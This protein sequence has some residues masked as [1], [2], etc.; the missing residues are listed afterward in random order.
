MTQCEETVDIGPVFTE[1]VVFNSHDQ[2]VHSQIAEAKVIFY[3]P[4][5]KYKKGKVFTGVCLF[6]GAGEGGQ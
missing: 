2:R 3:R 5:T 1:L 4:R 6:R